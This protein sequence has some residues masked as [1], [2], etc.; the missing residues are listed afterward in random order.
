MCAVSLNHLA[1]GGDP[2]GDGPLRD[3]RV[4]DD[5][6]GHNRGELA[7]FSHCGPQTGSD[8]HWATQGERPLQVGSGY[9]TKGSSRYVVVN[10][11]VLDSADALQ[12]VIDFL[13]VA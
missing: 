4:A 5:V 12:E 11:K 6:D 7:G 3:A 2:Q 9:S 1:G 8:Q 10:A 13:R